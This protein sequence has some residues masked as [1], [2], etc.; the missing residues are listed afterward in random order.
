MR[1]ALLVAQCKMI[2]RS[3]STGSQRERARERERDGHNHVLVGLY[4]AS[5]IELSSGF[6]T[7]DASDG[8]LMKFA[9]VE[10]KL[11]CTYRL[12]ASERAN[13]ARQRQKKILRISSC[14]R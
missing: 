13:R 12:E 14:V 3:H 1:L 5:R 4:A 6:L 9:G 7:R 11:V 10:I 8:I 2:D